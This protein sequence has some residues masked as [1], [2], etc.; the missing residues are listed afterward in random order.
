MGASPRYSRK[1]FAPWKADFR[2][3]AFYWIVGAIWFAAAL[4][5]CIREPSLASE[6]LAEAAVL[7]FFL[8]LLRVES[9]RRRRYGIQIEKKWAGKL[10]TAAPPDL[11]VE[12]ISVQ[13]GRE[14]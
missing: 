12:R 2:V 5:W 10:L 11:A 3:A 6:A 7:P 1:L 8:G 4:L 14:S 9:G 13:V